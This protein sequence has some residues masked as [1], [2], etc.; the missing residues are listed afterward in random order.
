MSSKHRNLILLTLVA[1]MPVVFSGCSIRSFGYSFDYSGVQVS[2]QSNGTFAADV[3]K[4]V[5]SNKWGDV[6]IEEISSLDQQAEWSWSG[7]A[8]GTT[9]EDA[10]L[11]LSEL[12]LVE[13][14]NGDGPNVRT[15]LSRT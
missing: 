13:T 15:C 8:W 7:D 12:S 10:E 1:L 2:K 14:K 9:N 4:I 11:F 6:S 5:V 3:K